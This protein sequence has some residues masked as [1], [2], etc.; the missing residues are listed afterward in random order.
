MMK[1]SLSFMFQSTDFQGGKSP[2]QQGVFFQKKNFKK[3]SLGLKVFSN[4][5]KNFSRNLCRSRWIFF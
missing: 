5:V 1:D 3:I 2:T 4:L